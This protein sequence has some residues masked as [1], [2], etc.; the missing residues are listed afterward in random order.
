MAN[1]LTSYISPLLAQGMKSLRA[2]S[3]LPL[4]ANHNN[5]LTPG[6]KGTTVTLQIPSAIAATDVTPGHV[7]P[8][9]GALAPTSVSLEVDFWKEAA[10]TLTDSDLMKVS[11]GIIPLQA[12][13]AIKA[14]SN[15][16]ES[17]LWAKFAG[18]PYQNGTA[19]TTPFALSAAT[20][21]NDMTAYIA[22]RAALNGRDVP[23][24]PRFAVINS[25]AAGNLLNGRQF[26]DAAWAATD[27]G[28]TKG[29]IG[30]KLGANW[31]ESNRVLSNVSTALT[32]GA[33]TVNG[34]N[35]AGSA[36][37]SLA[38]ATNAAPLKAGNTITIATGP[39]A[40]IYRVTA[41]TTLIVGNTSVPVTPVLRGATAGAEVVTLLATAMQN[42]LFHRDALGF[43]T[44]P[45]GESTP[46]G[47]EKLA[48]FDTIVDP[49]S[50]LILR[51]E[52]TRE[53]KQW[54]WA[55]DVL[56][57]GALVRPDLAQIMLG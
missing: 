12:D 2:K 15:A 41:D 17:Y 3:I 56:A 7:A 5:D 55:Y 52:L 22:A 31:V 50:G 19:G 32:A 8:D 43:V 45:L 29:I 30:T 34:V 4:L 11:A 28:I 42:V 40:G 14:I 1:T 51:L 27:L 33:L 10:F 18:V 16:L 53:Y 57:G 49:I 39:A 46:P 44:R 6:A 13:E 38:K 47:G 21:M 37:V 48:V 54:R 35:A 9:S 26:V 24:D 25:D 36:T 23:D 20:G